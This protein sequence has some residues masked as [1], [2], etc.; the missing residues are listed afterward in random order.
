M[1]NL[2]PNDIIEINI[3]DW[4][5]HEHHQGGNS[6][7]PLCHINLFH[8]NKDTSSDEKTLLQTSNSM[9]D[10]D[11]DGVSPI[12]VLLQERELDITNNN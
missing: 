7:P 5:P 1:V 12:P 6:I 11:S 3:D 8:R 10:Y 4:N 2:Y 9:T